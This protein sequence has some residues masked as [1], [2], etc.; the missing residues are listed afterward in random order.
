MEL[1]FTFIMHKNKKFIEPNH[2]T[3][4]PLHKLIEES[5]I[6]LKKDLYKYKENFEDTLFTKSQMKKHYEVAFYKGTIFYV[7]KD[8]D[9]KV[10]L[11]CA[12]GEIE[13]EDTIDLTIYDIV[14]NYFN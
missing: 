8:S 13:L 1:R 5:G 11:I 14:G 12:S 7:R 2:Y 6:I 3:T 10:T 9:K 4:I